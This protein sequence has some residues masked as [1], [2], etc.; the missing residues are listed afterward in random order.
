MAR[1]TGATK[2]RWWAACYFGALV[3]VMGALA[4]LVSVRRA[5]EMIDPAAATPA[6]TPAP[7]PDYEIS[8]GTEDE[9]QAPVTAAPE[10]SG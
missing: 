3:C 2:H 5:D 6:V 7:A 1:L 4:Y 9:P 10:P 8:T